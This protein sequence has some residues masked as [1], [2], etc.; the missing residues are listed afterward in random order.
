[1]KRENTKKN[2]ARIGC[3]AVETLATTKTARG[4]SL[5]NGGLND[6]VGDVAKRAIGLN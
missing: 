2:C 6:Q 1:M 4:K 3:S 5:R